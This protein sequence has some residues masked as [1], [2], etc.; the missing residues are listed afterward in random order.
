MNMLAT[1]LMLLVI[2]LV[3]GHGGGPTTIG[4]TQAI[5]SVGG[6]A[7][8]LASPWVIRRI[9]GRWL[10]I[11]ASWMIAAAAF[12]MAIV[13]WPYGIGALVAVVTILV[14]PVNVILDTYEMQIIPDQLIG[15]VSTTMELAAN[16][17]RWVAPITVG[18]VV[19]QTSAATAAVVWGVAF[20]VMAVLVCLTRSLNV[21]NQPIEQV[22]ADP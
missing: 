15:R 1:G 16:G 19:E 18:V 4:L 21:L 8:A 5:A 14:I 2:L 9:P 13:P 7:G 6:V 11:G 17:L 12:G 3:H 20:S 10:T 22:R